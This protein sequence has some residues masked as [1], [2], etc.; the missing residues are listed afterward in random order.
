YAVYKKVA[1]KGSTYIIR[2]LYNVKGNR[3]VKGKTYYYKARAYKVIDGK[4]YY[5]PMSTVKYI[6]AK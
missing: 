6:K 3:L 1:T 2:N 5:G 4:T